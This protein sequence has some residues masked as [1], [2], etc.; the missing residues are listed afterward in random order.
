MIEAVVQ[1]G[2]TETRYLRGGSGPPLLVLAL[3]GEEWAGPAS[4]VLVERFRVYVPQVP[5]GVWS[6]G[7][8]AA[9]PDDGERVV[10]WVR[11]VIDG[12]GLERP[13]VVASPVLAGA[14]EA[15]VR[16]D[17]YRVGRVV[18]SGG[19]DPA[20]LRDLAGVLASGRGTSGPAPPP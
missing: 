5:P 1:A 7:S 14:I 9:A 2:E 4:A 8:H 13:L 17:P 18:A 19:S 15:L 12:L 6:G 10:V 16:V 20:A 3:A 11:G